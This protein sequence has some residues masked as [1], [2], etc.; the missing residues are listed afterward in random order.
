MQN[1]M[2]YG[3][4]KQFDPQERL[5][6]I[7][8]AKPVRRAAPVWRRQPALGFGCRQRQRAACTMH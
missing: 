8:S 7:H 5:N 1:G 4:K 3:R 6:A 2:E